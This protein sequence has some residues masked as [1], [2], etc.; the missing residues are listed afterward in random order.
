M[1]NKWRHRS[2]NGSIGFP[3]ATRYQLKQ[4]EIFRVVNVS[5]K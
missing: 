3:S 5:L 1:P 4:G 2:R